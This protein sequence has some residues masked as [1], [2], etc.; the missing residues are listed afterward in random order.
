MKLITDMDTRKIFSPIVQGG[1][2]V[3][4][5]K[6]SCAFISSMDAPGNAIGGLS[7]GEQPK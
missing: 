5:R 7:V 1:T 2:Y 4:L 6:E 3:D